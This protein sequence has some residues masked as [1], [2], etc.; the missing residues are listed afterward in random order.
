V[1]LVPT[2]EALGIRRLFDA[3]YLGFVVD[4][5]VAGATPARVWVDDVAVPAAS[6]IWDGSHTVYL[7]GAVGDE[8]R[9]WRQLFDEVVAPSRPGFLKLYLSEAT[10]AAVFPDRDLERRDRVLY[11]LAR[12]NPQDRSERLPEGFG[13]ASITERFGD[14][15]A[16]SGF[17][18]VVAEIESGW[19]SVRE[20]QH[21]GF[22]YVAHTASTIACWCT[23]EYRSAR[24]CGTGIETQP[25]Y[26]RRGLATLTA[27]AFVAECVRRGLVAYWDAW[28]T[29]LPSIAVAE[30][31]GFERV[32][33]YAICVGDFS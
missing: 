28:A 2:D 18:D 15:S 19:P 25:G 21:R 9:A 5:M 22:G 20:F 31:V 23:A 16:L 32:A 27:S 26:R 1:I 4:A 11:R 33:D 7:A 6:L 10:A 17:S 3:E 8:A 30:R 13:I 24:H 12:P 29:N 14:L